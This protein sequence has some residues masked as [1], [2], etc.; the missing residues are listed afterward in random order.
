MAQLLVNATT[1]GL[2]VPQTLNFD[3]SR[4]QDVDVKS[5]EFKELLVRLYEYINTMSI[6][7]NLKESGY[8]PLQ[9]FV[10]SNQFFQTV[11]S[12]T[13]E[14]RQEF[15]LLVNVGALGA[16]VT[17]V[18]HGLTIGSTWIFT[19]IYGAASYYN[20]VPANSRYYPLPYADPAGD[21]I[22]QVNGTDVVIT[23]NSGV[24]FTSCYVVLKYVK[25]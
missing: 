6:T 19:Q 21:I 2:F 4:L 9:E 5:P 18:A 10:T 22:L 12:V 24:A 25:Q 7:L 13:Q 20:A 3:V 11:P 16:G 17:S 23:N 1:T 8:Y 15:R 14:L